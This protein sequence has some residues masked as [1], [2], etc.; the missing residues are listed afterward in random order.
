MIYEAWIHNWGGIREF[1][2]QT[3]DQLKE[4]WAQIMEGVTALTGWVTAN[5]ETI[6]Q[7]TAVVWETV[8]AILSFAWDAIKGIVHIAL[9][10][11]QG[12]LAIFKDIFTGNWSKLW[13]DCQS[14]VQT[15]L[16]DVAR[17]FLSFVKSLVMILDG[18]IKTMS[19]LWG[20]TFTGL[21]GAISTLNG[22][23]DELDAHTQIAANG[24]W[25]LVGAANALKSALSGVAGAPEGAPAALPKGG[26]AIKG[27]GGGGGGKGKKGGKKDDPDADVTG[28]IAE[29][30]KELYL[31]GDA[32]DYAKL[33]YDLFQGELKK[34]SAAL[35]ATVLSLTLQAQTLKETYAH[36]KEF[37]DSQKEL[38]LA[39]AT[40]GLVLDSQKAASE[41]LYGKYKDWTKADYDATVALLKRNE[42]HALV[43]EAVTKYRE[44]MTGAS[45]AML[46]LTDKTTAAGIAA[47]GSAEAW[48]LLTDTSKR[49]LTAALT[50]VDIFSEL[51]KSIEEN[52]KKLAELRGETAE[53]VG[54]DKL[55]ASL[56]QWL[57]LTPTMTKVQHDFVVAFEASQKALTDALAK[58]HLRK[59]ADVTGK[60]VG[61]IQKSIDA[62]LLK[63]AGQTGL[64]ERWASFWDAQRA[65]VEE[66]LK[67]RP[68]ITQYMSF[69]DALAKK[70]SELFKTQDEGGWREN[71]KTAM[72][73]VQD[74][75][76][77][78]NLQ[79]AYYSKNAHAAAV[80][81]VEFANG[82]RQMTQAQAEQVVQAEDA[83]KKRENQ[84]AQLQKVADN[85]A[86]Y[87]GGIFDE[88]IHGKLQGVF[89]NAI[90]GFKKMLQDMAAE[91]LK[92]YLKSILTK[93]FMGFAGGGD[94]GGFSGSGIPTLG[95]PHAEN[96]GTINGMTM[97][98]ESGPEILGPSTSGFVLSNEYVR[99][100]ASITNRYVNAV[101]ESS[102]PQAGSGGTVGGSSS[103]GPVHVHMTVNTPDVGG[104]KRS[105]SQIMEAAFQHAATA[106]RRAGR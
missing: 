50:G 66:F 22:Y 104:F 71:Y 87:I 84:I 4:I 37:I 61:D 79:L 67:L 8:G 69:L 83:L 16:D 78:I 17:I 98:G 36:H 49:S 20:E 86:N 32:S 26:L 102:R 75:Q 10:S 96:G 7:A 105:Q 63:V 14:L 41:R 15:I 12:Y 99:N 3:A 11:L 42:A 13:E 68:T 9:D 81:A 85:F 72:K 103:H 45:L 55:A 51:K 59:L 91:Y 77:K 106:A 6:K 2:A 90:T 101:H 95:L 30:R 33:H 40:A 38:N 1:I 35:K 25:G 19:V 24:M 64:S 93:L 80:A 48:E 60:A 46:E 62:M 39:N 44:L 28:K 5:W 76:E 31:Q 82:I 52:A 73:A 47:M 29:L 100:L 34:T 56:A 65:K 57:K 89:T 58:D 92:S 70:G 21:D 97:V 74:Q 94:G 27:G 53:G 54:F 23:L 43:I 88:L 18:L